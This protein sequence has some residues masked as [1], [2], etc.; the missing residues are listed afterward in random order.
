MTEWRDAPGYEGYYQASD[1]GQVTGKAPICAS[2]Q[3]SPCH[4]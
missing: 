2:K 4:P 3:A 1:D